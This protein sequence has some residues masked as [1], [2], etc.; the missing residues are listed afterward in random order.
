MSFRLQRC[1]STAARVWDRFPSSASSSI[2][3][4]R[5][6]RG[7]KE[8]DREPSSSSTALGPTQ[9]S[10]SIQ[11]STQVKVFGTYPCGTV[12]EGS[13]CSSSMDKQKAS[14]A[15]TDKLTSFTRTEHLNKKKC[16]KYKMSKK[17][18]WNGMRVELDPWNI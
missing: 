4:Y 15:S 14:N 3:S 18:H 2:L 11:E 13:H 5:G 10:I 8:M 17:L 12:G 16:K 6:I 9:E 1:R 7:R